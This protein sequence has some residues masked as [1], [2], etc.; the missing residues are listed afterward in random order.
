V[1]IAYDEIKETMVVCNTTAPIILEAIAVP[2]AY[3]EKCIFAVN[4]KITLEEE[5][6]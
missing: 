6:S 3:M 4:R 2:E 5:N 1:L